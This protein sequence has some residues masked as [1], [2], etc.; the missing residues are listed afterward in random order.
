M[1]LAGARDLDAGEAELLRESTVRLLSVEELSADSAPHGPIYLHVDV[2]VID[3]AETAELLYPVASGPSV[4]EVGAAIRR[5]LATERV[6]A[7]GLGCTWRKDAL[8]GSHARDVVAR[9]GLPRV[10]R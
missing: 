10:L 2:D 9:L 3:A 7:V 1:V 6:V 8:L 4:D 5:V